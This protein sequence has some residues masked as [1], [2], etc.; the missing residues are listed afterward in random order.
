MMQA[1]A[2]VRVRRTDATAAELEGHLPEGPGCVVGVVVLAAGLSVWLSWNMEPGWAGVAAACA[3]F[4][5][6]AYEV[7][8]RRRNSVVEEERGGRQVVEM[9]TRYAPLHHACCKAVPEA[10]AVDLGEGRALVIPFPFGEGVHARAFEVLD[11]E[12]AEAV[13]KDTVDYEDVVLLLRE[14]LIV[15]WFE[16]SGR[17]ASVRVG[18]VRRYLDSETPL[19]L[20]DSFQ[21]I[22]IGGVGLVEGCDFEARPDDAEDPCSPEPWQ[23]PADGYRHDFEVRSPHWVPSHL[24]LPEMKL[25]EAETIR[26]EV[27]GGRFAVVYWYG[28]EVLLIRATAE[29]ALVFA[30]PNAMEF[31][32]EIHGAE[33]RFSYGE[34]ALANDRV[35]I[36]WDAESG[37][38]RRYAVHGARISIDESHLGPDLGR[39][40]AMPKRAVTWLEGL[41][42]RSGSWVDAALVRMER[43]F[44]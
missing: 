18:G 22:P 23:L 17:I 14:R 26:C 15:R 24:P 28:N 44:D 20:A 29:R 11:D 6:V 37:E 25:V 8:R 32:L 41:E 10:L 12:R 2:W 42:I 21:Q 33:A 7:G 4:G 27:R 13:E 9:A 36:E 30:Y 16:Q 39:S 40:G 1:E 43:A 35:T 31:P 19:K 38:L 5:G 34:I 3:A